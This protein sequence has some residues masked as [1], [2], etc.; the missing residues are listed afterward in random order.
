MEKVKPEIT[1]VDQEQNDFVRRLSKS[2]ELEVEKEEEALADG[3]KRD[4]MNKWTIMVLVFFFLL[5]F[6]PR[7]YFIFRVSL[8]DNPGAGWFGDAYHHW[9]IAY[10]SKEIGFSK[11]F[12]RLWDLKGMEYFWGLSHPL[13]TIIAFMLTGSHSVAVE[14]SMTALFGSVS[15]ALIFLAAK[16][17]WN[18]NVGVAAA[19][20]AALNPVGV[21]NDGTGMVEPLGIPFLLLGV[22]LWPKKPFWTGLSFFVALMARGEYWVFSIF[23]V[24]A[25]LVLVKK[26]KTDAKFLLC[27]GFFIPLLAYMKYLLDYT[28]NAAYPFYWNYVANIFG[29][30]QLKPEL[31]SSDILAKY[32]FLAIFIVSSLLSLLVI[33]KKPKGMFLYL[34]G[35]GNWV[36][37]GATFG[38]GA[39]IKSYMSYVW[40]VRFMI[41]P[42]AFLGIALSIF[43]FYTIPNIKYLKILD[44]IKLNWLIL[45]TVLV[46]SQGTW[47]FIWKKYATTI[48]NW[49][50]AV[51]LAKGIADQYKGGGLLLMDGNPEITYALVQKFGVKGKFI[52]GE[53]FDPYYYFTEEDPYSNWGENRLVVLKW[54]KDNDIRTIA[55]Y[56]QYDR[57]A[58]LV[59]H[60]PQYF[61]EAGSVPNSN[62]VIYKVN[63]NLF[64]DNFDTKTKI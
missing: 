23:L 18:T 59:A 30:W 25:M 10:L 39:Y 35:L 7:M 2:V 36:F 41:L 57:Y 42:Y 63:D 60:E 58:K 44:K 48:P 50:L 12:L 29:T 11:S 54:I 15:V 5:A 64:K 51:R 55:T 22:Y 43:L 38:L 4:K 9:Q 27:L 8:P 53:M 37:L 40:Y 46:V 52:V 62:I 6:I 1:S 56:V 13:F 49:N 3:L 28:G 20:L 47:I 17:F 34:L 14:R 32:Q 33:K 31:T 19:L 16:R 61:T 26:I 24:G 21:F 45:L